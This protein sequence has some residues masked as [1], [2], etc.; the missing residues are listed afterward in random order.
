MR[1]FKDLKE[2]SILN[3][4]RTQDKLEARIER[5]IAR[6]LE[7]KQLSIAAEPLKSADI[8]IKSPREQGIFL[9]I[10]QPN[11]M[12]DGYKLS[13]STDSDGT[14]RVTIQL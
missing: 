10:I 7:I 9:S 1:T 11:M 8:L 5:Q 3:I 12:R 13:T 6:A 14:L 2:D 4:Q